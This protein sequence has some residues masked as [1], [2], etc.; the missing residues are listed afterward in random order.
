MELVTVRGHRR[1]RGTLRRVFMAAALVAAQAVAAEPPTFDQALALHT[2]GRRLEALA[3]Y[4][5]VGG[6]KAP[7]EERAAALN[8]ACVL[9][10]ELGQHQRAFSDCDA[11]LR[12]R[13][14]LGDRVA[15]AETV[16]NLGLALE[17]L[18]R[19]DEAWKRFGEALALNRKLGDAES[20]VVNL[21]NLGA[22]AIG[23]GRYSEA[24]RLYGEAADLAVR[25]GAAPWAREQLRVARINQ[26]VVL[27]KVGELAEAIALYKRLLDEDEGTDPRERAALLVNAGV[28]YRNLDDA[29]S[30]LAAFDEANTLYRRLGDVSGLSNAAL[31][32]G[33]ALHLNLGRL[34]AAERAYREALALAH[35]SGDRTEEVQDLF[36]LGRLLLDP[37]AA[38]EKA[39]RLAE[40][41]VL[42]RRCLEIAEEGHS[43]EGRW[44]AL[45]G[46]G[47]IAAARGDL[48]RALRQLEAALAEIERVRAGL[49]Q[50]PWR[51]G[52]FG[53]KRA[54]Y[55]ATV[56]VLA[57][58]QRQHAGAGYGERAFAVVQRAK[59]RDLLDLLGPGGHPAPPRTA[60]ELRERLG[61]DTILEYFYGEGKLY[62]WLLHEQRV[63]L[64][65]LGPAAPLLGAV[66]R[67]HGALARGG[68]PARRDVEA[69][70]RAL[71]PEN[72]PLPSAGGELRV[73]PDGLLRYLPFELLVPARIERPLIGVAT[74]SYLPSASTLA[75]ASAPL[76]FG[77]LRLV[78]FAPPPGAAVAA[79][80]ET[81]WAPLPGA[82]R[83][84]VA[85][86]AIL[87]GRSSLLTGRQATEAEFRRAALVRPAVLHFATH[88]VIAEGA[89]SP[90]PQRRTAIHLLPD[91]DDDGLLTPSEI[92]ASGGGAGL[93]VLAACRTA[94]VSP[95]D[96]GRT[97]AS[98]TGSFLAAGS[99]AVVATLWDVED[100]AAAVFMEQLYAQLRRGLS[101]AVALRRAKER[102][103]A[104]PRWSR[105]AL[106]S[107]YVLV[108]NG[109]PVAPSP[110]PR[111]ILPAVLATLAGAALLRGFSGSRAKRPRR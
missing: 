91:G 61:E 5:A 67:V 86:A 35:R 56:E 25:A 76:P 77:G 58:L 95:G 104:D 99:P 19:T 9:A 110:W 36:Y 46:L 79:G 111:L 65:D 4:R 17:A 71:L 20:V 96:E 75:A 11:A 7:P 6:S 94:I 12:L 81:R 38:G 37:G 93:T 103:R 108:G 63:E 92:A 62:R 43:A 101:P 57:R 41:E 10:G 30:A 49:R 68:E 69:L 29:R 31:N 105:P 88:A 64:D 33:L 23:A 15:I 98:L 14:T 102:L 52:Y 48:P 53:D 21:G 55:A 72:L 50:A 24:M 27:E 89:E 40:A 3:A 106:W 8:N 13:H 32:R 97:L 83:E 107:A 73:A 84:V 45:E 54:V 39:S 80:G 47:R 42:F 26:G 90:A 34:R 85:I 74:V 82:R 87:G 78:A 70:S 28:I 22:L 60:A 66:A 59:A 2:A 16:N 109:V 51:A 100:E 18:G 44:S 1:N